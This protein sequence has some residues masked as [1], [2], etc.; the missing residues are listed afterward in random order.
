MLSLNEL[1]AMMIAARTKKFGA[2]EGDGGLF[3]RQQNGEF[4]A[5]TKIAP[6][7]YLMWERAR[8]WPSI[9]KLEKYLRHCDMTLAEFFSLSVK[10]P[11]PP[12]TP[13][14][15][16]STDMPTKYISRPH[17]T[18]LDSKPKS[19]SFRQRN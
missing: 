18:P 10:S 16:R 12:E 8:Q 4:G 2:P 7:S 13:A 1:A 17:T 11:R 15:R 19:K 3:S 9:P 6:G 5:V 14:L